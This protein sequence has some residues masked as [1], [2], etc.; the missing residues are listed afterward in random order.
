ME[1]DT[2]IGGKWNIL[3]KKYEGDLVFNKS[4]GGIVLSIYYKDHNHFRAW[5]NQPLY[6]N[7]ITGTLN[8][9]YFD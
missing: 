8:Q 3:G 9:L 7:E 4:N 2:V 1:K 5:D 6:M